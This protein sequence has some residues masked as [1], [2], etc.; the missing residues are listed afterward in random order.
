MKILLTSIGTRGDIEPFIAIGEILKT[1]GHKVI[2]LFPQQLVHLVEE[3]SDCFPLSPKVIELIEGE[4]G[5]IIMGAKASAIRKLKALF[6]LYKEGQKINKI[7]VEQ[8]REIIE[9]ED[10]EIIV[11][12]VK[13]TFPTLWSLM[14]KRKSILL[15]P[16]PHFMYETPGHA[17]VGFNGNYGRILNTLTYRLSNFGLVKTIYDGQKY[18]KWDRDKIISKR[19]IKKSLFS[20]KLFYP[21]SPTLFNSP[22]SWP[23]HVKVLGFH[24]KKYKS[25]WEPDEQLLNFLK[26]NSKCLFLTFGSM[27]NTDPVQKSNILCSI[28]EQLNIPAIINI[29]SGGLV[30]PKEYESNPNF[31]FVNQIPYSWILPRVYAIIHHGGSGTT[32]NAIKYGCASLILPHIID[33]FSWNRLLY[34][35]GVGPLGISM[36]KITKDKLTPLI[37]DLYTNE[38][39]KLKV[40]H[41]SKQMKDE[42]FEDQLVSFITSNGG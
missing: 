11:H 23:S 40:R 6:Y 1:S 12:N 17:H 8:Q 2:Y 27:I 21:I 35:L 41:L 39:Y 42:N 26:L 24:D 7:L 37:H 10:P 34:E 16:V 19:K 20:K 32:H 4:S 31:Y 15:S 36:N 5:Q 33:Q 13:C 29:A 22:D 14:N 18:L 28:L 9:Q 38:D 30:V 3:S 25:D